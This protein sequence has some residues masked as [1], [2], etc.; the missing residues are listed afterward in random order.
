MNQ[1]K[2][3]SGYRLRQERLDTQICLEEERVNITEFNPDPYIKK[4]YANKVW[5]IS[6]AKPRNY[7]SKQQSVDSSISSVH[8]VMDIMSVTLSE[9]F[10]QF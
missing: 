6:G 7:P 9:E 8:T 10:E 3:E 4:L 2:T 1:I 5:C